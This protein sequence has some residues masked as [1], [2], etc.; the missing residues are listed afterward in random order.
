MGDYFKGVQYAFFPKTIKY[1][2]SKDGANMTTNGITLQVTK[3]KYRD[4][5]AQQQQPSG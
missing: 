2:W 1:K 3:S 4:V 5:N